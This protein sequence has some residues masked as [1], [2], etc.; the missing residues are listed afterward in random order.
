MSDAAPVEVMIIDETEPG[1][2]RN[3]IT[4]GFTALLLIS[5]SAF[6]QHTVFNPPICS[7]GS[8]SEI[9]LSL[10]PLLLRQPSLLQ[11]KLTYFSSLSS[12][13][14]T[15]CVTSVKVGADDPSLVCMKSDWLTFDLAPHLLGFSCQ[16]SSLR[17]SI[18]RKSPRTRTTTCSAAGRGW[19]GR[20]VAERTRRTERQHPRREKVSP[21][22]F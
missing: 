10:E 15:D 12:C 6:S 8:G 21:F 14:P 22:T 17:M 11:P 5:Q 13:W 16:V 20:E 7:D 18:Q 1:G 3:S 2:V 4:P 9:C 19:S